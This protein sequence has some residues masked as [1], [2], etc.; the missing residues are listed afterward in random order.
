ML[1]VRFIEKSKQESELLTETT[2]YTLYLVKLGEIPDEM[3]KSDID[4]GIRYDVK[5][6]LFSLKLGIIQCG[7]SAV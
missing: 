4:V 1:V 7:I 3:I 2:L 6:S 5:L